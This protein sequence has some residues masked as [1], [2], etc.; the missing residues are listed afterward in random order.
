[1]LTFDTASSAIPILHALV[2]S[3]SVTFL[4][5]LKTACSTNALTLALLRTFRRDSPTSPTRVVAAVTLEAENGTILPS[6]L[7]RRVQSKAEMGS[8]R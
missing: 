6:K 8:E 1:M 4:A 7:D 2:F 5:I 3:V